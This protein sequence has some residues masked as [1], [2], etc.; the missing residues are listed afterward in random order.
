MYDY[1]EACPISMATSVLCEKW[2]LQIV[3][4]LFFGSTRY[5]EIQKYI[6]NLS[7]SLLRTRLR[8]LE[9]QGIIIRKASTSGG[10]HEYHLTPAGKALAPVLTELGRWGMRYASEGMTDKHNPVP[11][12]IRDIAGGINTDE[13]PSGDT[14]IQLLL[15]DVKPHKKHYFYVRNNVVQE[16]SQNLG[17][18]VDVYITATTKA[19]TR[20][21]Y[22]ETDIHQAIENGLLK[23]VG[24]SVYTRNLSRWLGISSFT[25][26]N[27][28]PFQS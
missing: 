16:C 6:P 13:L 11:S 7:P 28:Q 26:D 1:G 25:S 10:R 18:D 5:S 22:G 2:T 23:V 15:T 17:F 20:V 9:E 19:L 21:W 3:R 4:E 14:V 8:F 24:P 27:P 12:L